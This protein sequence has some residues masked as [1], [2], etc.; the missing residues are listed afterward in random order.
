MKTIKIDELINSKIFVKEN[1]PVNFKSPAYYINP[2]LDIMGDSVKSTRVE[3]DK[4][5]I[6]AEE[7]GKKNIAYPRINIECTMGDDIIGFH[8]TIGLI[9]ALD[10]QIPVIKAYSG[11]TVSACLNLCVFN[12]E[13]LFESNM[14]GS[15]QNV[16]N[17][18]TKFKQEKERQIE[19][20]GKIYKDMTENILTPDGLKTILGNLLMKGSA[21]KLGT[22]PVVGATKL[23][24]DPKSI[25]YTQEGEDFNCNEWNVY[26]A[27]T[28][29]LT[30]NSD[31]V[32]KPNKTL[33][34][35][36]IIRGI[37][38]VE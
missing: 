12:A 25:Y 14:L 37:E 33:E 16:Y 21:S 30:D 3:V 10:T 19:E 4:A 24:M 9:Y 8:S 1:S 15:I 23:L 7:S 31:P 5:I 27:V 35:T 29:T 11:Q 26:N 2:F 13:D 38:V 17:Q 22:S 6:N 36:N 32:Y 20:Y 34:L 18:V 28:Q